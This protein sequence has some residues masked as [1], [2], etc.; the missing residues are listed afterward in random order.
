M[1]PRSVVALVLVGLSTA[2]IAAPASKKKPREVLVE[3]GAHD[4]RAVVVSFTLPEEDTGPFELTDGKRHIP[5]QVQGRQASFVLDEMKKG[6][7]RTYTLATPTRPSDAEVVDVKTDGDDAQF[8]WKGKDIVKYH[9][10]EGVLPPGVD[11]PEFR[12]AGYLHPILTPSGRVITDDYPK[13]HRHHHGVWFAW[14]KTEIEGRH[15]DFWNMGDKTGSVQAERTEAVWSGVAEAGLRAKH[16]Y[17]DKTTPEPTTALTETWEL[18]VYPS[19]TTPKPYS[20]FDLD[21]THERVGTTP[22][23]LDTY[24]YGGLGFRGAAEWKA[25][26]SLMSVLTSE[27]KDR[28][29]ANESRGRWYRVSGT[30]DG[31]PASIVVFSHPENFRSPQPMRVNPDD[32]FICWAP[33]QLG[34][35]S[36]EPGQPYVSRY[37][38]AVW[39]EA[40]DVAEIERLWNDYAEPVK[41]ALR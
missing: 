11:R 28:A 36:I 27:G 33:P 32:P 30:V 16:K 38:F 7:S 37:R 4:R 34:E 29:A 17:V 18:H 19:G 8:G 31:G 3:A 22:M 20:L 13:D 10:G 6:T 5:V 14:T 2:A 39:D 12:R 25:T 35:W 26:P 24:R 1:R 41:A 21:V 9:G 40:P 15:P 23:T